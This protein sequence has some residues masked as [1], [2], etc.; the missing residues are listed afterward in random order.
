MTP[1]DL[2]AAATVV[3]SWLLTYAIH[4][5]ILL[6]VAAVVAWRF[7]DQHAWLDLIWKVALIGP[8]VTASLHLDPIALPVGGRWAMPDMTAVSGTPEA[9]TAPLREPE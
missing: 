8:L 4:S 3:I 1:A 9:T 6:A 5:T 7:A 2:G